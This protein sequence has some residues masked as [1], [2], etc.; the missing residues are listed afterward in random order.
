MQLI[1]YQVAG[2]SPKIWCHKEREGEKMVGWEWGSRDRKAAAAR[3]ASES[4]GPSDYPT[5]LAFYAPIKH[6]LDRD[7]HL[8]YRLCCP[9]DY[10]EPLSQWRLCCEHSHSSEIFSILGPFKEIHLYISSQPFLSWHQ[11]FVKSLAIQP[12]LVHS[13]WIYVI[14]ISYHT[15]SSQGDNSMNCLKF[16]LN[17]LGKIS[18]SLHIATTY[19]WGFMPPATSFLAGSNIL[20][21]IIYKLGLSFNISQLSIPNPR[22]ARLRT[23]WREAAW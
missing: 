18:F 7:Y 16:I 23:E 1:G 3:K 22:E 10:L 20:H 4:V 9:P 12:N 2:S 13:P 14:L 8:Q 21:R 6:W 15:S 17:S 19:E 5:I 11:S